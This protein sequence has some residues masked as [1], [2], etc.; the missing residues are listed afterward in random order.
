LQERFSLLLQ[1]ACKSVTKLAKPLFLQ[2]FRMLVLFNCVYSASR[3]FMKNVADVG[4]KLN[5][6]QRSEYAILDN[7]VTATDHSFDF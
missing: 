7:L 4:K 5:V 1:L 2:V 3:Y 6:L